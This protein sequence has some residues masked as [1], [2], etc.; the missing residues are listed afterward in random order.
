M[1][2]YVPALMDYI[3]RYR[4]QLHFQHNLTRVDGP[5]RRAWFT[6]T[7]ADGT[8]K[9]VETAFDMLHVVPPQQAPDVIRRSPLAD[10]GGWVEACN[11]Y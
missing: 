10:S 1:K 5:A 4:A 9:T 11:C 2:E 7:D 8:K 3:E 6:R